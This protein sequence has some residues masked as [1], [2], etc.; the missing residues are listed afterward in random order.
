MNA[1][2]FRECGNTGGCAHR[3]PNGEF[4]YF[5]QT[6]REGSLL[7]RVERLERIVERLCPDKF[8]DI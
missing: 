2:P 6:V 1:C 8:D 3:G 4:C 5:K 7:Q